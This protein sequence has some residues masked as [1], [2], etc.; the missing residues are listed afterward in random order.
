MH[1]IAVASSVRSRLD[2]NRGKD[3]IEEEGGI[4]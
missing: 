3:R 1:E 4:T 2:L